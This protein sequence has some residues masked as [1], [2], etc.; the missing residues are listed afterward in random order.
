MNS[1]KWSMKR[2][3]DLGDRWEV[4]RKKVRLGYEE[5]CCVVIDSEQGVS[6]SLFG[7][8]PLIEK[9]SLGSF[10]IKIPDQFKLLLDLVNQYEEEESGKNS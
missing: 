4:A 10:R 2:L 7:G 8:I 3:M 6:L 1:V 9:K 5:D